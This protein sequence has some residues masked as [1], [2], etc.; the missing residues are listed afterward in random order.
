M[1]SQPSPSSTILLLLLC[2]VMIFYIR[3]ASRTHLKKDDGQYE[4]FDWIIETHPEGEVNIQQS[5]K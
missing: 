5:H 2:F 1:V 3:L 4:M